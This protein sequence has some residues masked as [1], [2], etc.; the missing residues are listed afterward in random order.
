MLSFIRNRARSY[1]QNLSDEQVKRYRAWQ[2]AAYRLIAGGNLMKLARMWHNDKMYGPQLFGPHYDFHFAPLRRQ[3]LNVLE[4][5][6]GGYNNPRAGGASIRTWRCYFKRANIYAID[7]H[8]GR[9]HEQSRVKTFQ[10][11]QSDVGFLTSVADQIGPLDIVIDD[12]SHRNDHVILGFQTLFPRLSPT[13]LYV[14]E[15]TQTSYWKGM[16]G[17]T[18]EKNNPS[19][20]MGFFKGLTD[21]LNYSEYE[22]EAYAPTAFDKQITGI[23]FYHNLIFVQKGENAGISNI[24]GKRW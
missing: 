23:S 17:D 6:I 24:H 3:R 16:G 7:L 9:L 19:T 10:G 22:L 4:I 15:D 20:I 21:G 12:G 2:V 5:G 1:R 8:D 18:L 11:D 14:V 13:G